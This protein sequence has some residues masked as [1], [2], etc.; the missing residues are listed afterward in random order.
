MSEKEKANIET[1]LDKAAKAP[2]A[3]DAL[4]F[5]QAA[6]NAATALRLM[7]GTERADN[8]N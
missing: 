6:C 2:V 4:H 7:K 3:S 5:S 8:Q 1:L